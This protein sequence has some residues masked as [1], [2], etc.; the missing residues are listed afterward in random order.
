MNYN[1]E[2]FEEMLEVLFENLDT[3]SWE[4][5]HYSTVFGSR[6]PNTLYKVS[7]DEK[8]EYVREI[9]FGYV[10]TLHERIKTQLDK[11]THMNDYIAL[12]E[13]K[14]GNKFSENDI[15]DLINLE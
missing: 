7:V 9:V 3:T 10:D 6:E 2:E 13:C 8:V 14:A 4:D 12:L 1:K 15:K 5:S 11:I